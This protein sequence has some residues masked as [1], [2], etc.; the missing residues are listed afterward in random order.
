[1]S[2]ITK[3]AIEKVTNTSVIKNWKFQKENRDRWK[4]KGHE[5]IG[6]TEKKAMKQERIAG[7]VM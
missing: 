3:L 5:R 4:K 7:V 1:M 2:I 6:I